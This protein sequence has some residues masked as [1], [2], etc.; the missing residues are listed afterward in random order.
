MANHL[1]QVYAGPQDFSCVLL[2]V[3]GGGVFAGV[4]ICFKG[5]EAAC[6]KLE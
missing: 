4:F 6:V 1:N 2:V 3:G 5:C